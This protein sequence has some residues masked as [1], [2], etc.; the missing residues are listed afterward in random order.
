MMLREDSSG[1]CSQAPVVVNATGNKKTVQQVFHKSFFLQRPRSSSLGSIPVSNSSTSDSSQNSGQNQ[2]PERNNHPHWQRIPI[3]RNPKRR[4][5]SESPPPD[6]IDTSNRFSELPVDQPE[7]ESQTKEKTFKEKKP[8]KPPPI[9]LYGIDDVNKLTELLETVAEKSAFTYKIV[10]RNQLRINSTD[11][12]V[13]KKLMTLVREN[14]LIGHTFNRKDERCYRIVIKNLHHTTPHDAIKE[15]IE[16][17]GNTIA[18]EI[19]NARYG[20]KKIPTST[21]FVNLH[22]GPNNKAAKDI[23]IIYHQSVSIEDPKKRYSV[24]QCQRCQ[25]YGHSK[26]YCL[27]PYRCVKCAQNHKTS[28][29]PKTDRNTPATCALCLGAH[30][31]NY[32]GCQVYREILQRKYKL[33][34]YRKPTNQEE[35]DHLKTTSE[36][37]QTKT[38]RTSH[39]KTF[40]ETLKTP[41]LQINPEPSSSNYSTLEQ[42]ILKQSEKFDL[43]LQ[44]MSSLISLITSLVSKFSS[45]AP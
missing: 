24:I 37:Q 13:Y 21:F 4:K 36:N 30:P 34:S 44:Q 18:G 35:T 2:Q 26:N 40:A 16:S 33:P 10:N 22:P 45:L 12:E 14:G 19:I 39:K 17:T 31:A 42:L 25:Q 23:K 1:V 43:I 5:T 11:V 3:V 41:P 32:K 20:P 8:T 15:S 27:R 29:C 38:A 28:E 9:I 7:P 6:T